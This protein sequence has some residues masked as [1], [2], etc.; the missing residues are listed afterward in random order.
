MCQN[1][2]RLNYKLR[3]KDDWQQSY[4]GDPLSRSQ[5]S[6]CLGLQL[7]IDFCL[8]SPCLNGGQCFN[9]VDDYI[10]ECP[11]DYEGKNCS[12]LRDHCLTA[13]CK[14]S[15]FSSVT[16]NLL[17]IKMITICFNERFCCWVWK[18]LLG[19]DHWLWIK[20]TASF[21]FFNKSGL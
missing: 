21:Y 14:G 6:S 9:S 17:P 11:E 4:D 13:S 5:Q 1:L 18:I 10:C 3:C 8:D 12:R 19:L 20:I 16:R 7:D 2:S 15:Q